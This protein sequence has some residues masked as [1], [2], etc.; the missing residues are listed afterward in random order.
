M[1][2][3]HR[4]VM[5]ETRN[6]IDDGTE[7]QLK[8]FQLH[9]HHG[10]SSLELDDSAMV[11]SYEEYHPYGTTAF[12]AGSSVIRAAAKRYRYTGMERDEETG[13]AYH[14]ARYYIPWL[15][16]WLSCDPIGIGDS[17]NR[18]QYAQGR[19][20]SI[21]DPGGMCSCA[22]NKE[23]P[24]KKDKDKKEKKKEAE[25]EK[26][27]SEGIFDKIKNA[28]SSFF[29]AI[30]QA[31]IAAGRWIAETAVKVWDWVKEAAG[32][33]W[34]WIK[35]AATD[36]W[37]WIKGALETAWDW[38]KNAVGSAWNWIKGAAS[39]AWDWIKNAAADAWKWMKQAAADVWNWALAPL[40]RTATNAFVGA[41]PGILAGDL[42]WAIG[43]GIAGGVTGAV[44]G[45]S[46]AYAES[47]DWSSGTGWLQ[48]LADN[49]WSLPNSV[50]GSLFATANILWNPIDKTLS[51]N[52]GQLYFKNQWFPPYDTTLPGNVTVGSV[53]PV[54]ERVHTDQARYF[55]P[56]YLAFQIVWYGFWLAVFPIGIPASLIVGKNYLKCIA[57][58]N[59]PFEIWA[60]HVEGSTSC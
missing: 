22:E 38:T 44:H 48:F 3:G 45:W 35:E 40:I 31:I 29:G 49:T 24:E 21:K 13:L 18:Y 36:A 12:L 56:F 9:N 20:I 23:E 28:V 60:Y 10:S 1:D 26:K 43:G 14:G 39:D 33:A 50:I 47:Y 51:K 15:G 41:L 7:K 57:Y 11:I 58:N 34:N 32:A 4:F 42:G 5:I 2:E 25:G 27:E 8:R 59:N 19:P 30:G 54:H 55:G 46:M 53:V 17:V 37:N 52:T 16:R 6:D